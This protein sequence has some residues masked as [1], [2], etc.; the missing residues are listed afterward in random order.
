MSRHVVRTFNRVH[1]RPTLGRQSIKGHREIPTDIRVGILLERQRGRCVANKHM[2]QPRGAA[3]QLRDRSEHM[4]GNQMKT[5][6]ELRQLQFLLNPVTHMYIRVSREWRWEVTMASEKPAGT[7][8]SRPSSHPA[9]TDNKQQRT[10]KSAK[11]LLKASGVLRAEETGVRR[12]S[13]LWTRVPDLRI[14]GV[15]SRGP[16]C[17]HGS[18]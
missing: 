18:G 4:P 11:R 16:S 9:A 14:Q 10:D 2:Q 1:P 17:G 13:S 12:V 5:P 15:H 6:R 7:G 8:Y 3:R